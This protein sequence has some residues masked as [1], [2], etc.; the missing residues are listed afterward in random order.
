MSE[1]NQLPERHD[2]DGHSDIVKNS[3]LMECQSHSTIIQDREI[4]NFTHA[5][6]SMGLSY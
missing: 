4:A 3:D 1:T 6:T 2:S 5:N